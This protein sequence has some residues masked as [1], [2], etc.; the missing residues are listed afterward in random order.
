MLIPIAGW[1]A[2]CV[3]FIISSWRVFEKMKYPGWLALS[4]L[5]GLIWGG[6][7]TLAYGIIIGIVAWKKR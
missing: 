4:P 6:L 5:L 2:V 3:L 1:I 7:G